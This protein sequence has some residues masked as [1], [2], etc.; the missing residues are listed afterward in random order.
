MKRNYRAFKVLFDISSGLSSDKP[1][2]EKLIN[3]VMDKRV[4]CLAVAS[5]NRLSRYRTCLFEWLCRKHGTRL[6]F[7]EKLHQN[8]DIE[9][10]QKL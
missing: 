10:I 5:K 7:L 1:A 9:T 3:L 4:D 8:Q 6:T 2:F